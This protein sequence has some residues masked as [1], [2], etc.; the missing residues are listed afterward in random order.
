[1]TLAQDFTVFEPEIWSAYIDRRFK[2]KLV[3]AAFFRNFSDEVTAGG[4][5]VHIP[6][7]GDNF[8][9]SDIATTS[10]EVTA[11]NVSD[12]KTDLT[13]SNWKGTSLVMT[14]YEVAR[15]ANKY[16]LKKEYADEMATK[17]AETFDAA[18]LDAASSL[19]PVVGDSATLLNSTNIEEAI[20][21][22]ESNSVPTDELVFI[23]HPSAY[24]SEVMKIQKY[25]DASQAGWGANDAPVVGAA[26]AKGVLYGIPVVVTPQVPAGTAGTEGGHRNLLVHKDAIVYALGNL[27]GPKTAGVR[28]QEKPSEH[29]RT[30]ITADIMYG[31]TVLNPTH[32]VRVISKN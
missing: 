6:H 32:G 1:M 16:N 10:G 9:A 11:T 24:W 5:T 26:K 12:T 25:Y 30:R 7:I 19:T 8:S 29:L 22:M 17:L 20:R 13:I 21:I 15:V 18:L 14:D 2:K 23:F 3:A 31:L 4:G 27:M 28:V